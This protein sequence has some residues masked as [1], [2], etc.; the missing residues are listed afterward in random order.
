MAS[1]GGGHRYCLGASFAMNELKLVIAR[2]LMCADLELELEL[3]RA[4]ATVR[5]NGTLAPE[6]DVPVRILQ[7]RR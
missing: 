2:V 7:R 6:A 3:D 4:L 1:F 5:R